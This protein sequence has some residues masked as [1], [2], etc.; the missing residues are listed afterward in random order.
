[1]LENIDIMDEG[2]FCVRR[3]VVV[4]VVVVVV[5]KGLALVHDPK[6]I[7]TNFI[8]TLSLMWGPTY[9]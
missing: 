3:H 1:M 7:N 2:P 4:V 8:L 6:K 5:N 9:M